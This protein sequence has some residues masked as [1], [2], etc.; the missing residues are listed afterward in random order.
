MQD[1]LII[2]QGPAGIS[3]ALYAARAGLSVSIL[4]GG[5]G[6]LAKAEKIENYYGFPEPVSGKELLER[7]IAQAKRLGVELRQEEVVSI[8]LLESGLMASTGEGE[9]PARAI[10]LAT[11][12]PRKAPRVKNLPALEGAGVSYCAICDGFFYRGKPV[13]VL[14]CCEYALHEAQALLPLASRV[15]L[16]TH[17]E[18]SI[19]GLPDALQVYTTPI[20]EL[21]GETRLEGAVLEDG[22]RIE[23]AGLFVAQGVAGSADLAR[24]LGAQTEGNKIVVDAHMATSI[25]GLFAAGDCTGGMLQIAKAVCQGAEAGASVAQYLRQS[26]NTGVE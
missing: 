24:K 23:L 15:T 3:A 9:Y 22:T 20:R 25:P 21:L 1:V 16:L 14:G 2:G 11:G 7:G 4:A 18:Q 12:A 13:G 8:D 26:Q 5:E 6:A 10:I 17:G 19:K